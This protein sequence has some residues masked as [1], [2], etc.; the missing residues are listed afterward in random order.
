MVLN[1]AILTKYG[2]FLTQ[3]WILSRDMAVFFLWLLDLGYGY[4]ANMAIENMAPR[5]IWLSEDGTKI[6]AVRY[7]AV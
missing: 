7:M 2:A 6:I 4:R 1:M 3:I 5:D